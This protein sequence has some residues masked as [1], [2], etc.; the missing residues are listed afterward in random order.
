MIHFYNY[1][2]LHMSI[3]FKTPAVAHLEQGEQQKMWKNKDYPKKQNENE[4]YVVSLPSRTNRRQIININNATVH[5]LDDDSCGRNR[6]LH[7][8]G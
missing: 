2:R 1:H 7:K 3:G 5:I 8:N 6:W 4:N